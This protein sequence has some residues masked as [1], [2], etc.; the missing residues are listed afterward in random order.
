MKL[1]TLFFDRRDGEYNWQP[2]PRKSKKSGKQRK[3]KERKK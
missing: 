1:C 2:M 3:E